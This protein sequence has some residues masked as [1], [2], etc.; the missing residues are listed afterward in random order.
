MKPHLLKSYFDMFL[1][2]KVV[3]QRTAFINLLT[4]TELHILY[5]IPLYVRSK[6]VQGKNLFLQLNTAQ[7]VSSI[8]S[9]LVF[10]TASPAK[11]NCFPLSGGCVV[12]F[13]FM[14]CSA[15]PSLQ[16]LPSVLRS[17]PHALTIAYLR[18]MSSPSLSLFL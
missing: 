9:L 6:L 2:F 8:V 7:L 4:H 12:A 17:H 3:L 5:V 10:M 14:V 18:K 13:H 16:M 1:S 11:L 15:S